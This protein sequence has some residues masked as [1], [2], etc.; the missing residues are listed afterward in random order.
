MTGVDIN[1]KLQDGSDVGLHK[2]MLQAHAPEF[3]A[4]LESNDKLDLTHETFNIIKTQIYTGYWNP[5]NGGKLFILLDLYYWSNKL[6]LQWLKWK[7][8]GLLSSIVKE[9]INA[10]LSVFK[11]STENGLDILEQLC[12][13]QVKSYELCDQILDQLNPEQLKKV[14]LFF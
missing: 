13:T 11:Y 6:K 1:L 8:F 4:C 9:N 14:S 3:I 5:E 2:F 12:L 7:S 10:L